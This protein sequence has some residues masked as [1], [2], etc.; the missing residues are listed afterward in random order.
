MNFR[1]PDP[2]AEACYTSLSATSRSAHLTESNFEMMLHY[3]HKLH[4]YDERL[5]LN[6]LEDF[7][8]QRLAIHS[9]EGW[10]ER[11]LL[12]WLSMGLKTASVPVDWQ[13]AGPMVTAANAQHFLTVLHQSWGR[14]LDAEA[15]QAALVL[16]WRRIEI[17]ADDQR[18]ESTSEW[19]QVALH[20]MFGRAGYPNIGK[21]QRKLVQYHL[22]RSDAAAAR[23]V[24]SQM[25]G[26]TQSH[27]LSRYLLY[28][29]AT[30]L[31]NEGL[32][33][34]A[35]NLVESSESSS[36]LLYACVSETQRLGSRKQGIR[37]LRK[38]LDRYVHALIPEANLGALLRCLIHLLMDELKEPDCDVVQVSTQMS[39]VFG[40][41]KNQI[42][43]QLT[44]AKND[45]TKEHVGPLLFSEID[46]LSKTANRL[47]FRR[48]KEWPRTVIL[49]I[50]DHCFDIGTALCARGPFGN[51]PN[52]QI[53]TT[54]PTGLQRSVTNIFFVSSLIRTAIAREAASVSPMVCLNFNKSTHL[55][56]E[57]DNVQ[58][59]SY[60]EVRKS[61]RCHAEAYTNLVREQ[62]KVDED[63]LEDIRS[64]FRRQ[65]LTLIP[66][67]LEAV[68]MLQQKLRGKVKEHMQDSAPENALALSLEA[69]HALGAPAETYALLADMVLSAVSGS[70]GEKPTEPSITVE[71]GSQLV[72]Q[73]IGAI[74]RTV[75]YDVGQASRWIR[76]LVQM[77][78]D[79]RPGM[80]PDENKTQLIEG[81]VQQAVVLAHDTRRKAAASGATALTYPAEEL[82]WLA[83]TLF[84]LAVDLYIAESEESA[85]IWARKAVDVAD[86]LG[87]GECGTGDGGLLAKVLRGKMA[88]L[89][90]QNPL[91][92]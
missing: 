31:G 11:A 55:V 90:W 77:V 69:A 32:A 89:R 63:L 33:S 39:E 88:E 30:R 6:L 65:R 82:E 83:T 37:V 48:F 19:C 66:L 60:E 79:K 21:I 4:R 68:L 15:A 29:T 62:D 84:N 45:E 85:K 74:R 38:L 76:C 54:Y 5:A 34:T 52:Q 49:D 53:L 57:A 43:K 20:S 81:V 47:V 12:T 58:A 61:I 41:T 8:V 51:L 44:S 23:E 67:E 73:L 80:S 72:K 35:L 59:A 92:C 16:L 18:S 75:S 26:E 40:I 10:I 36:Q 64:Q 25:A 3:A 86:V 91:N 50:L 13:P 46:W 70:G 9:N 27:Y 28:C 78:T 71:L 1:R 17:A 87:D 2:N 14:T 56:T 42:F 24:L 22:K 7:L